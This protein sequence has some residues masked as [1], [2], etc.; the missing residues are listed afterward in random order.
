MVCASAILGQAAD[1]TATSFEINDDNAVVALDARTGERRWT[2]YPE[3]LTQ[4]TCELFPGHLVVNGTIETATPM[5]TFTRDLDPATGVPVARATPSGAPLARSATF[6]SEVRLANGWTLD[7]DE[8]NDQELTFLDDQGSVA[9]TIQ[10]SGYPEHVRAWQDTVLWELSFPEETVLYA[11]EAGASAPSWAFDPKALVTVTDWPSDRLHFEVLG[12]DLYVGLHEHLFQLDPATGAVARQW[13]LSA[14]S[15]VPFVSEHLDDSCFFH[16]GLEMGTIA[17]DADTLVIGFESRLLALDRLR[18]DLLWHADPDGFIGQPFP[19]LH[20]G[21]LVVTAGEQLAGP[22][23]APPPE[24]P[25][26]Q[27][28]P[29]GCSAGAQPGG[30]ADGLVVLL[31]ALFAASRWRRAC[32]ARGNDSAATSRRLNGSHARTSRVDVDSL[33]HRLQVRRTES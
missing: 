7:F 20:D 29:V 2:Y 24:P 5:Q 3:K 31:G 18:G 32:S 21:L 27:L 25:P 12:D 1:A 19:L 14:L 30:S 11:H 23:P 22:R 13:D 6:G 9:W 16:G 17:A 33:A 26:P 4:A 15:S 28:D 8:G 10:T